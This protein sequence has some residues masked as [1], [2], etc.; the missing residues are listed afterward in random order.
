MD[1]SECAEPKQFIIPSAS[2]AIFKSKIDSV[3]NNSLE[4]FKFLRRV[5]G[6]KSEI[7]V[8]AKT[9]F[10]RPAI[11]KLFPKSSLGLTSSLFHNE[12]KFEIFDHPNIIKQLGSKEDFVMETEKGKYS[13]SYILM[14]YAPQGDLA[15]FIKAHKNLLDDN[16]IRTFFHQIIDGL[17]HM[18]SK[19]A[20]HLDIKL[21][22]LLLCDNYQLKI[23]DFDG[24]YLKGDGGYLTCRG[25]PNFRA[26]ELIHG[27]IKDLAAVDI[28]S[29]VIVL[30]ALKTGGMFPFIE[31]ENFH[32]ILGLESFHENPQYFWKKKC[33][34]LR[35][36]NDFFDDDFKELFQAMTM[37]DPECR[38]GIEGIRKFSWFKKETL[39]QTQISNLIKKNANPLTR[40]KASTA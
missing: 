23:A 38:V 20:Y 13:G 14:E 15:H 8:V 40:L 11:M 35:K 22:N 36:P 1:T 29:V 32:A 19:G 37:I 5:K 6:G 18:H 2:R 7:F 33:K 3:K 9:D 17:E 34:Q 16:L 27:N 31:N 4:E 10:D 12:V 24:S 30:F 21:H 39:T 25:T 26:P 28:Y